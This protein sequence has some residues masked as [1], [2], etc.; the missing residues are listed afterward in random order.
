MSPTGNLVFNLGMCP[1]WESNWRPFGLQ[2]GTKSIEPHQPGQ[3]SF[4]KFK[5]L[6]KIFS[7]S[8]PKDI[9]IDFI[10]RRRVGEKEGEIHQFERETLPLTCALTGDRT[11]NSGMCPDQESNPRPFALWDDAQPT[12]P[13]CQGT[14]TWLLNE[15]FNLWL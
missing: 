15:S 13:T 1:D 12:E 6:K 8:S 9:L 2:A 4:L 11:H 14:G 10:E 7:L 5:K 3:H